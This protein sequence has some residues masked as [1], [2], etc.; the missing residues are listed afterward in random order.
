[1][2]IP[3][4]FKWADITVNLLGTIV[5]DIKE[6]TY[7]KTVEKQNNMGAGAAPVSRSRGNQSFELNIRMAMSEVQAI[8]DALPA[9]QDETDIA[10]FDIPIEYT[11]DAGQL[12]VDILRDVEFTEAVGGANQGDME[13][14]HTIPGIC[15]RIDFDA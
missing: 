12:V 6:I 10:P 2:A 1:M 13:I 5:I 4:A 9:G 14:V 3:S 8:R 15:S 7:R 11:T